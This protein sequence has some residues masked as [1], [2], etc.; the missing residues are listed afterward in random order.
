M[1]STFWLGLL[2][3]SSVSFRSE[4][5]PTDVTTMNYD[6]SKNSKLLN[7]SY[8]AMNENWISTE[9][10]AFEIQKYSTKSSLFIIDTNWNFIFLEGQINYM[11]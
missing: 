6:V 8:R 2:N 4:I 9:N 11:Y 1:N 10:N 7:E 3:V 5:K